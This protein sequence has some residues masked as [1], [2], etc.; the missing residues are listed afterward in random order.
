[1]GS[2]VLE[3]DLQLVDDLIG[4]QARGVERDWGL[5]ALILR[6]ITGRQSRWQW[7]IHGATVSYRQAVTGW[8][9]ERGRLK[10]AKKFALCGRG[11]YAQ[12]SMDGSRV[13]V[14][15]RGCHC[16]FCPRCSRQY[17]GRYVQ[18]V[19]DHLRT[20]EHG[21]LWH[22]VLTQRSIE[23]ESLSGAKDRF[24]ASWKRFYVILRGCGMRSALAS[25]HMK[26]RGNSGWHF[27][28]HL[29][30]ELEP[31]LDG[32]AVM[33]DLEKGWERA[34]RDP[35]ALGSTWFARKVCDAG[36]AML[37]LGEKAQ[38]EFWGEARDEAQRA[39]QYVVRDT[40]QGVE[41][42]VGV[43]FHVERSTELAE[44]LDNAKLHRL[45]GAWRHA[46]VTPEEAPKAEEQAKVAASKESVEWL[47]VG[48]VDEV[49]WGARQRDL[50][51]SRWLG[52]L[53]GQCRNV[54]KV[55]LR[56]QAAVRAVAA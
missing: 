36:G 28:C 14:R 39:L 5:A 45:Y 31:G 16:R 3:R 38:G 1:M 46:V 2:P 42:W 26:R 25:Y 10:V 44:A 29:V 32:G 40:A 12:E 34:K 53:C 54:G 7:V 49:L 51:C 4:L 37:G 33:G 8:L 20:G 47:N 19:S 27:H 6:R 43:Q 18:R 21:S 55:A 48:T 41:D 13:R 56:L 52:G 24:G 23:G 30:V 35:L 15:T 50:R 17:G 9:C 11:D 22:V